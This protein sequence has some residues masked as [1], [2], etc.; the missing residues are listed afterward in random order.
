VLPCPRLA[1]Q[2]R[3]KDS[4]VLH[5]ST[6]ASARG[7]GIEDAPLLRAAGVLQ[8]LR[9]AVLRVP[10]PVVSRH[11]RTKAARFRSKS[12]LRNKSWGPKIEVCAPFGEY[13]VECTMSAHTGS[14]IRHF[15]GADRR[16]HTNG[17][18]QYDDHVFKFKDSA[19]FE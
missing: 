4:I 8:D 18:L 11:L 14:Y 5:Q 1:K 3:L 2:P 7:K 17:N 15:A 9:P 12:G 10:F 6:T 16:N 19:F 13:H